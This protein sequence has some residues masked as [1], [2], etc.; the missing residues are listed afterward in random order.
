MLIFGNKVTTYLN[1]VNSLCKKNCQL[2]LAITKIY[3][4]LHNIWMYIGK[5]DIEL[6]VYFI[7]FFS[8]TIYG[9]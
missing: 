3:L 1:N 8:L 7:K 6:V 9:T 4:Y 2:L 5:V